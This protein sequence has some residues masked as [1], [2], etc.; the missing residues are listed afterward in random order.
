MANQQDI[1]TSI[2]DRLIDQE[3]EIGSE[4]VQRRFATL[5]QVRDSV[6]RDLENLLNT[7]RSIHP[8]PEAD[9]QVR[10]SLFSYGVRD[11]IAQSPRSPTVRQQ[12]RQEIER[13]L[14]LFEP[15]LRDVAVR[16]DSSAGNER[17]LRFR[18]TALLFVDP[19]S[20][21]ITFDTCFDINSGAYSI[22]K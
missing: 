17:T 3:P 9:R 15:R 6:I 1:Q 12:I 22:P 4:P 7:R 2:L 11:F 5:S 13:I 19:V 8:V 14:A 16:L 21:P 20:V 18:I 10:E